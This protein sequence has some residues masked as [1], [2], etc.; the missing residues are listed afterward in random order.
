MQA[1]ILAENSQHPWGAALA[2]CSLGRIA[3]C[4][5]DLA[6]A[7]TY[8]Q[9]ALAAFSS[10]HSRFELARTHLDLASLAHTQDNHDTATTHLNQAHAWFKK[11]QVPKW[12]NKTE[13]LAREYGVTLTEVELEEFER[14][15]DRP[16]HLTSV[17]ERLPFDDVASAAGGSTELASTALFLVVGLHHRG[18]KGR[19]APTD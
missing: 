14:L 11:L 6:E 13:Q 2:Q 18:L 5:G 12:V 15:L 9:E 10:I 3:Q 16:V 4:N 8:F 19:A 17:E 7:R 1:L